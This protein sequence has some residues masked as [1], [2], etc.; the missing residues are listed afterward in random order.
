VVVRSFYGPAPSAFRVRRVPGLTGP[1][2]TLMNVWMGSSPTARER[3]VAFPTPW[4]TVVRLGAP[5]AG[6]WEQL[7]GDWLGLHVRHAQVGPSV[8]P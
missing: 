2:P 1:L 3:G 4:Q 5:R 8:L 7:P 6:K